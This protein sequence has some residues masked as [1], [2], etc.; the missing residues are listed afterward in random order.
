MHE[1][2]EDADRLFGFFNEI[3]IIGQLSGR[4]LERGLPGGMLVS[5]FGVLNHL[6]KR[7]DGATPLAIARAF[8]VPKTTMTHTLAG[9]ERKGLIRF[10]TNPRDGRSKRVML[11]PEGE[12]FRNDAIARLAPQLA[13]LAMEIGP[14]RIGAALPVLIAV[15]KYLDAER[16]AG[17]TT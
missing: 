9:L 17:P 2:D 13:K 8:Q 7:G 1:P 12:R 14:A 10:A 16:D 11:T 3:A 4:L 6:V 15:R 5:H